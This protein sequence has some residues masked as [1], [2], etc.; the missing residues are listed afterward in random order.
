MLLASV[1]GG[2]GGCLISSIKDL[3]L[4]E[5]P[6]FHMSLYLRLYLKIMLHFIKQKNIKDLMDMNQCVSDISL[7][8]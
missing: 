3:H 7:Y 5:M 1:G 2:G 4:L 8:L 6:A